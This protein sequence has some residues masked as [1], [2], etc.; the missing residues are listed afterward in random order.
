VREGRTAVDVPDGVEPVACD[1]DRTEAVVDPDGTPRLEPD[2]L[3]AGV[4]GTGAPSDADEQ[5]RAGE[6][7]GRP[8]G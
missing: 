6:A 5:L 1:A 2:G 8:R 4:A 7:R 3:E